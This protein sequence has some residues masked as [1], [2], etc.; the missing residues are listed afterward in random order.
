MDMPDLNLDAVD[1]WEILYKNKPSGSN[2]RPS[3][4]LER[5]LIDRTPG[6][7]LELGCAKGDDA[8]WLAKNGWQV[9][10]VDISKTALSYAEANAQSQGLADRIDFQQ[11][12][13][14]V[15][16]PDIRCDLVTA[17]FLQTPLDFP[18]TEV[19]KKAAQ[20]LNSEGLLLI[21][22]HGSRAPWSWAKA[23]KTYFTAR[24]S[25]RELNLE[26]D[27]WEEIHVGEE[28]RF[29]RGP[30]NQKATVTDAIIFLRRM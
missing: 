25:L 6:N 24:E 3:R 12:D 11:H 17:M 28:K 27:D 9:T 21:V 26:A 15:S 29:A 19:L 30:D 22:A 1:F 20:S 4:V 7:A 23:D 14:S 10:A 16:F 13:L 8:V 18:R 5:F 2:G